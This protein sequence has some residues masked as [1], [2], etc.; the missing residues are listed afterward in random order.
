[1]SKPLCFV[2]QEL[3]E[4]TADQMR[5]AFG[6]QM[7]WS[8]ETNTE[9][10]LLTLKSRYP[11][12]VSVMA[13]SKMQEKANGADWEFWFVDQKAKIGIPLRIQAKRIQPD[14]GVYRSLFYK[15]RTQMNKLI[16]R[17]AADKMFPAYVF[18]TYLNK[19][20]DVESLGKA[21]GYGS[22]WN[23]IFGCL[24]ASATAV[25]K[26]NST[27]IKYIQ[28]VCRP[29]HELVCRCVTSSKNSSSASPNL[30]DIVH[31][32]LQS[33]AANYHPERVGYDRAAPI[34]GDMNVPEPRDLPEYVSAMLSPRAGR[35][36]EDFVFRRS[37]AEDRWIKGIV[38]ISDRQEQPG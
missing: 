38:L 19:P 21:L 27:H 33:F 32:S 29:W 11:H 37:G 4:Q 31:N 23:D 13:F 10:I 34:D 30:P 26:Q 6:C 14:L 2:F 12:A 8:E 18:Y 25:H 36:L 22:G 28:N 15:R 35:E 3:A 16:Q 7:P 24:F 17:A 20:N 1:M 5:T 9:T